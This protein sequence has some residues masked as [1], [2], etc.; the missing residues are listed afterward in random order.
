MKQNEVIFLGLT[1]TGTTFL[2]IQFLP[3]L[4]SVNRSTFF[5][6]EIKINDVVYKKAKKRFDTLISINTEFSDMNGYPKKKRFIQMD[7][8]DWIKKFYL[9]NKNLK[10]ILT[11][12]D[13]EE[14]YKSSYNQYCKNIG[15]I[16]PEEYKKLFD[17][18]IVEIYY[19]YERYVRYILRYFPNA[20]ITSYQGLKQN[21]KE[22]L[23]EICDYIGV[24]LPNY[25]NTIVNESKKLKTW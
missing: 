13:K 17:P 20:L 9:Y 21:H 1:R 25:K 5:H 11:L 7:R 19:N 23:S 10:I 22:Y 2:R 12:R 6:R 24:D 14:H 8:F 16:N 18:K 3:L 15:Y 4:S